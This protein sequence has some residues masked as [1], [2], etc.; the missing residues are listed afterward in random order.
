MVGALRESLKETER[1]RRAN[2]QLT[3]ASREPI[4]IVAMSCRYPG[5]A[6]PEELWNLVAEEKDAIS[7]LPVNRGWDLD[8]LYDPDPDEHGKVYTTEGGFLHDADRFDP[9]FFGIS[10]REASAM[11]P[12]Q[13][14]LLETSWEAFERAGID[15]SALHGNKVGL[16]VGAAYQGWGIDYQ[17]VPDGVQGHLVTGMS[18]SVISGR[19]SYTLGLEGPAV[20]V[21]TACSSSLVALHLAVQSLRQGDCA[22]AMVGGAAIMADP[23]GLVGFSRQRGLALDGRCKAFSEDADGM[24][25]GEGVGVVLLERLSDAR[26]NGHP[27]LAV[28]R[29]SAINQDGASNGLSAPNGPAQQRVIRAALANAR[30]KPEQVD[31]VEAHGT[32]TTLGD[33]IEAGA[34]LATYGQG[35]PAER[36]LWLGSVKSNLGHAQAA[37]GVAGVIKMVMALRHGVLPRTLHVAEPSRK[38]DWE[39]GAVRLLT[40]ARPWPQGEEPRRAGVSSFGV[41]GTN[42]HIVLEQAPPEEP[43]AVEN[44][45]SVMSAG[46]VPLVVS[47]RSA[48]SLRG[49]AERLGALL[50]DGG[51]ELGE[52]GYSLIASRAVFEHRAVI[53]AT[54]TADATAGLAALAAD[55]PADNVTT[56]VAGPVG[57]RVFVFPGQGS[58]WAGMA[59]ELLDTSP[60]FAQRLTECEQALAPFVDWS[61]QDVLREAPG[62][63][64]FDRVDVVQPA[65]FAVMVSLSALWASLGVIPDAVVGHSQGEIAAACVAGALSLDD[66]ARVVTLRSQAIRALSGTGGMMSVSLPQDALLPRMAPWGERISLAAVNGPTSMVVAGEPEALRELQTSCETDGIRAKLIPVDYASHSVQVERIREELLETLAPIAPR[67]TTVPFYSTVTGAPIDTATLNAEYWYTNLRQTVQ[68]DTATKALA[69]DGYGVFIEASPHPVLTMALQETLDAANADSVVTGTL[70]RNEGGPTRFLTSAAH[71]F[72]HG[73]TIDWQTTLNPDTHHRTDLPTYAFDRR[74]YWLEDRGTTPAATVLGADPAESAF[75]DAVEREDLD[76][77]LTTL[78]L[79]APDT[80]LPLLPSLASWRRRSREQAVTDSWRYRITWKPLAEPT[81]GA[82]SGTWLLMTPADRSGT[83]PVAEAL[84]RQGMTLLP[85]EIG[86]DDADR[87]ALAA[88]I[89]E[90]LDG[91]APAGVLSLLALTDG[92]HPTH[93]ELPAGFA[94]SLTLIQALGDAGVD[95]P[96]WLATRGAVT[97]G[98]PES[99]ADPLQSMV[100][101]LGRIAAL[102]YPQ[103]WGGMIDLPAALDPVTAARLATALAGRHGAEAEIAVRTSAAFGRRLVRATPGSAER[104]TW[105]PQGT[106]LITGGTGGLGRHV[107]RWLAGNGAEHLVLVSRSGAA[108]PGAQQLEAELTDLGARVTLAACD[109]ADRDALAELLGLLDAEGSPV[110][111]VFHTAGVLDDG[112][113]DTLTA[114]RARTVL[115]PKVDAALNLHELTANRDLTA[116]VLFSSFAGTLGGPGQGSYAAANAFLDALAQQRGAAGLA[117]TSVAW[118][119]WAGGGLVDDATEARL[120]KG[121]M[122]AMEPASAIAALQQALDLGDPFVAVADIDWERL[123]ASSPA[124]PTAPALAELPEV[125]G[126]PGAAG[127]GA[128]AGGSGGDSPLAQQ[129]AGLSDGDAVQALVELVSAQVAAVLGYTG[130]ESVEEG[131]AFRELGFDSL[132]AVD[133]RNRLSAA[134]GMRLPVTLVFDYPSVTALARHLHAEL[135]DTRPAAPAPT[136][137]TAAVADD[138]IAIVAMSCRLPGGVTTPEELWELVDQ[139]RDAVAGFPTGRGWDIEGRYDPDPDKPGTFYAR[140]GGFL[141]DAD[142]FDPT[143]FGISPREALAIDPQQR[144]LLETTW[145]AFERAGIA[146]ESM[147]GTEAGVFIGASYNDYGS[148]FQQAPEEFEGY[149]ATGSASS[150]ASGR[151]SYTFGLQGP[152]LTVD[153]ACSSS[154]LALHL[155]AQSLRRGECSMALAGGVVVMSTMDSFIEFSRQRAMSPDGRCRAFSAQADGAGWSE[156]VGM[157]LLERLSDAQRNGHPVLAVLRGSAVNQDG[158]SNGLTAPNGP[159]QQRVI[160]TALAS[161]GLSPADVDAVEAHGTGTPLGDPIEAGALLATYGQGRPADRPLWLGALKSNIGHTQAASGVAGVIKTVMAIR[162]GVLPRTLHAD[163]RSEKIDWSAG[164]V[165]LLTEARPWPQTGAPR[166]AGVSAFGVSG[167]NVHLILEQAPDEADAPT[168]APGGG[169]VVPWVLSGKSAEALRA[170][171]W[172]LREHVTASPELSPADVGYSLATGRTAFEHRAVVVGR[173]V[174]ELLSGL[175]ALADGPGDGTRTVSGRT[176]FLFT[177]QGAQRLGMGQEL[178]EAFPVFAAA[179]DEVCAAVDE[180]LDRPLR[181]VLTSDATALEG[182]GYAQAALFAIEVALFRLVE[183]WGIR[184]DYLV[185]HSVG[186]LAAAHV[187]GV[188]SLPDACAL[189]AARG[190]LMQ[191]LPADGAMVSVIAT[192]EDLLPHLIGHEDRVSIAAL[193]GPTATVLSGHEDT[194]Q[195]IVEAGGW[196]STRLRVSHAFHSPLMEPMLEDFRQIAQG[197]EYHEPTIALVSNVTGDVASPELV[198]SPDYWVRHVR[199]SVRFHD[200][201]TALAAHGVTRFVEIGPSAVLTA[202]AHSCVQDGEFIPL[203]RKN[204]PEDETAIAAL[205]RLHATGLTVDWDTIFTGAH[206]VDLPTYAF[207]RDRYWLDAPHPTT[208]LTHAGLHTTGHPLLGAALPLA[209]TDRLIL[210]GRLSTQTHPWLADHAVSGTTLFPGTAF[211][212]LALQ[213]AH[214][215]NYDHIHELTLEAPLILPEHGGITLQITTEAPDTNNTRTITIHSRPEHTHPD[216]PWTRHASGVVGV[217]AQE[218]SYDL[219][220]V[221]PPEGA[222]PIEVGDLYERFAEGGFGYGPAFQG[223]RAAWLVGDTVHAEVRLPD[224][225]QSTAGAYGLHPALLDAALHSIA[226]SPA[227]QLGGGKLP[228]SWAGVT[229]HGSGAGEVR[230]RLTP[231]GPDTVSLTLSDPIGRP[232]ATVDSLALRARPER[233]G[234]PAAGDSLYVLDWPELGASTDAQPSTTTGWALVGGDDFGVAAAQGLPAYPDLDALAAATD[235]AAAPEFVLVSCAPR[236]ADAEGLAASVR[237]ALDRALELVQGWL[238]DERFA[239]SRMV[240]LTRGAVAATPAEQVTDLSHA[241]VWGLVRSAQSE[242]PDRFVLIDT[243]ADTDAANTDATDLGA[244]DLGARLRELVTEEPQLALRN[245]SVRAARLARVP[246]PSASGPAEQPAPDW[247]TGTVLVT[248]ATGVIGGVMARHLVAECGVRHL[249]LTSRRGGDADGAKELCAEL[250]ALGADVTLAACDVADRADLARLL[251]GVNGAHPLTAV[252]HTAGV[253]DD[254]VVSGLTP[255]R[256]DRVLRPKVDAAVNLHELTRD[257]GLSALVLFSSIAGTFGGMGQGNYAAANAFLDAYATHCRAQGFPVQSLAWG[258]WE[259]RSEMTGKLADADLSRLARGGIVAFSSAEGAALFDAARAL[260]APVLL[261]MR[262]DVAAQA[263]GPGPVPPLLRSLVRTPVRPAARRGSG[264]G[265]AG[266]DADGLMGRLAGM[267]EAQRGRVLLDLVRSQAAAVLGFKD[268]NAIDVDRGLLEIG[269]D[270]LTAVELR[271]QLGRVTGLRL[272]ATLLFDYPTTS[273]IAAHL[274]ESVTP[275]EPSAAPLVFPELDR[276]EQD[277]PRVA[278]DEASR[279]RL[280]SRLQDLLSKLG[281][282]QDPV[283][284][285]AEAGLDS[286]SDDEIFDFIENELGLS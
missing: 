236:P 106:A 15:P 172:R 134:T 58:Q 252:V 73:T 19:V 159:A 230:V 104:G 137:G 175:A 194:V 79:D 187:A 52:V 250:T 271:N 78:D 57:R 145:E 232:V 198:C 72:T 82:P 249:L 210:T 209:D 32:G 129:L 45:T 268:P 95:A 94:H 235:P 4:G 114:E 74:S 262:L 56:A 126:V 281:H 278:A 142:H 136:A 139:G 245:G 199:G 213:T 244:A 133:L 50:A 38:V 113:I 62:A 147:K 68:L 140:G 166:R 122:P 183:S 225:Q 150:V 25:L 55:T 173:D 118:G 89:R 237:A 227:L 110:R 43:A 152:S 222:T 163:E 66:A 274:A 161:A 99:V 69:R 238:A 71:L 115:R 17:N 258:L 251:A 223:I 211:L 127:S 247:G 86:A 216:H 102:E 36:P 2:Q 283:D 131:R 65:L 157:I 264:G 85:L 111:S 24:G 67:S 248:G 186:E 215:V 275:A 277:L 93:P 39:S 141:Y 189:V 21:D 31:L 276:L 81:P 42:A 191:A 179:F 18:T 46:V 28:I 269:F 221:W 234:A 243:D 5:V 280:A 103:R 29:G 88:R 13:R 206:R 76:S 121:G 208:D 7:G 272:A 53:L 265:T 20:T 169:A 100:W 64:T 138:P 16:F 120:R 14:L 241:A 195:A 156:G 256:V 105:Q 188:W 242:N 107:A 146:P 164:A 6:S 273:A 77:L 154:L 130:P 26:R 254:G 87:E 263:G 49:Q 143:F 165:E 10:P 27:V 155:A 284:D 148:R 207:Q 92:P 196:K 61:L 266:E 54:D 193:N 132:T 197:L 116:F 83:A 60:V 37:S 12:Q 35:R 135:V 259:Q 176:A 190:R 214:R 1:L 270:S 144:L 44:H 123:T 63:P 117:A 23:L 41:S 97:T 48:A 240:F 204:R 228:F 84:T 125:R 168:A 33:P 109:T 255:E 246:A 200:G 205:G 47:A 160:Q 261:P 8:G 90:A 70:R 180:H 80:L 162:Q 181:E 59:V 108:A 151:V 239:A 119:P 177:G 233:L 285:L 282:A 226:L 279:T 229:L 185:G 167:T 171:A 260:D 98:R 220:G 286:A 96:L 30:L 91:T 184:A 153:T 218:G 174:E 267:S 224:E 182:T 253:L 231:V 112:V 219:Q 3:A 9:A 22:M 158:A 149:L 217:G 257:L 51:T 75:W 128:A 212:E 11:D 201:M 101:G 203:L 124:G 192:E 34:L 170:Q 178:Y 40:E 202:M